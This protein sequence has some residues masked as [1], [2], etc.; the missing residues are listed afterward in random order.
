MF[1]VCVG[2]HCS[3]HTSTT[4][5]RTLVQGAQPG[6]TAGAQRKRNAARDREL[7]IAT[8]HRCGNSIRVFSNYTSILVSVRSFFTLAIC[9]VSPDVGRKTTDYVLQRMA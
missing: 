3:E 4:T 1:L 9:F 2:V 8:N 6:R 5:S 7:V